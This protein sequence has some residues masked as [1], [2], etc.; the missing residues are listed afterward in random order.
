MTQIYVTPRRDHRSSSG[1]E[2]DDAVLFQSDKAR[3]RCEKVYKTRP[4]C[5]EKEIKPNPIKGAL[6]QEMIE[7]R[8]WES[9]CSPLNTLMQPYDEDES[10]DEGEESDD[11]DEESDD[12]DAISEGDEDKVSDDKGDFTL[13]PKSF[14]A[15]LM[16]YSVVF[17]TCIKESIRSFMRSKSSY[18]QF[19]VLSPMIWWEQAEFL[20]QSNTL[21]YILR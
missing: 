1:D 2:T 18:L 12:E 16:A 7:A 6:V 5:E 15:S 19:V 10:D 17:F 11:E 9:F 4:F 8:N 13:C 21:S 14:K 3:K 20:C